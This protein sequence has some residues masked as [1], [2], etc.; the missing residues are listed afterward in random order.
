M[1]KLEKLENVDRAL[2]RIA[3]LGT[4]DIDIISSILLSETLCGGEKM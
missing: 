2:K 1:N 4:D 3:E